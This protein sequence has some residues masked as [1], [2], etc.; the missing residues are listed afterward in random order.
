MLS[1]LAGSDDRPQL[2]SQHACITP[3]TPGFR[4]SSPGWAH[5]ATRD[6][7]L[8]TSG[9]RLHQLVREKLNAKLPTF[10]VRL[11]QFVDGYL[12]DAERRARAHFEDQDD[13][14]VTADDWI[15]SAFLPL[16]HARIQLPADSFPAPGFVELSVLFWTG[17]TAVGVQLEPA[18]SVIGSKKK[19]LDWLEENWPALT[20]LELPRD[21]FGRAG[22]GFPTGLFPRA[23]KEF[24]A[25]VEIPQGPSLSGILES[26]LAG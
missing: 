16:P 22:D 17:E 20:V 25:D 5:F 26:S 4:L 10:A 24:W 19:H 18:A 11:T 8:I 7:E 12:A 23:L 13:A 21:R 6:L 14:L 1:A 9:D 2:G 3:A 15:Y